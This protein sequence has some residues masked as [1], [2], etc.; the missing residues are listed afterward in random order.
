MDYF[1]KTAT[2]AEMKTGHAGHGSRVTFPAFLRGSR[3][4]GLTRVTRRR[5]SAG[6]AVN[7]GAGA[8]GRLNTDFSLPQAPRS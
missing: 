4:T 2:A 7:C 1:L 5:V 8:S 6:Q 3:V